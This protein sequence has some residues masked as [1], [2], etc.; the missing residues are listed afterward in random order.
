MLDRLL[1]RV[2]VGD[3]WLWTGGTDTYGY[4]KISVNN[5]T[6]YTHRL[7][8]E[9]LVGPIPE[10]LEMDH[11]CRQRACMNPDHLEPVTKSENGRRGHGSTTTRCKHGHVG[12]FFITTEGKRRCQSCARD[13]SRRSRA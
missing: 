2:D 10:G 3:C 9:T 5:Q 6:R 7:M 4:G 11:L 12:E 1:E 8:W 13:Q